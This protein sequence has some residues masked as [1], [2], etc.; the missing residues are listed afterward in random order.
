MAHERSG[1]VDSPSNEDQ[2]TPGLRIPETR[3]GFF[4]YNEEKNLQHVCGNVLMEA[5]I[6]F[7]WI[8]IDRREDVGPEARFR[9]W[10]QQTNLYYW[11]VSGRCS[12]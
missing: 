10:G 9:R 2:H 12:S 5:R 1:S 8:H 11:F 4:G 7:I 6:D 3:D